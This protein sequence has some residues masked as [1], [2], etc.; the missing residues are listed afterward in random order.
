MVEVGNVV[1]EE[2]MVVDMVEED[3]VVVD[4]VEVVKDI[5][6]HNKVVSHISCFSDTFVSFDCS[7][8]IS[9]I[10]DANRIDDDCCNHYDGRLQVKLR[11]LQIQ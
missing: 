8:Y 7:F 4:M 3:M 9:L 10:V 6:V 2:D 11:L 1:E 5:E